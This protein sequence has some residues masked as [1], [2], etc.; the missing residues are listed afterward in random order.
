MT[1]LRIRIKFVLCLNDWYHQPACQFGSVCT[2]NGTISMFMNKEDS[3]E[4]QTTM[5][6]FMALKWWW[7]RTCE[8]HRCLAVVTFAESLYIVHCTSTL[9][10]IYIIYNA[11]I[12]YLLLFNVQVVL[13]TPQSTDPLLLYTS[14]YSLNI[15]KIFNFSKKIIF[16]THFD[17]RC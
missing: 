16:A 2:G 7:T 14:F 5:F 12:N 17:R 13:K 8:P 6:H 10:F 4:R 11:L 15:S 9:Y 3:I 1:K